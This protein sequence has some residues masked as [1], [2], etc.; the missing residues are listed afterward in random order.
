MRSSRFSATAFAL[1]AATLLW[2][3]GGSGSGGSTPTAPG[4]PSGSV[5]V[6]IVGTQGNQA[7]VPNPVQAAAGATVVWKNNDTVMH[8]IVMDNGSAGVGDIAP[9]ASKSMTLS[10]SGGRFH[11]TIHTS[12]VGEFNAATAPAPPCPDIYC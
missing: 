4:T 9:G 3:C 10:G 1:V 5:T 8:S 11:C 6:T 12:M 7:Y 2:S